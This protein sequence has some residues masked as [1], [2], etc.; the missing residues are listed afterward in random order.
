MV[1]SGFSS[2]AGVD[3]KSRH[4]GLWLPGLF[5]CHLHPDSW[6]PFEFWLAEIERRFQGLQQRRWWFVGFYRHLYIWQNVFMIWLIRL[7][8]P[9]RPLDF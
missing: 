7:Y 8:C 1:L 2:A 3:S 5:C 6:R 9:S 4:P